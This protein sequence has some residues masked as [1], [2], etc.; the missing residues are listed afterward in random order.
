[1][2]VFPEVLKQILLQFQYYSKPFILDTTGKAYLSF[3]CFK[4]VSCNTFLI[5]EALWG[6]AIMGERALPEKA[7]LSLYYL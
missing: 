2:L 3:G 4:T 5:N 7:L 1:M 6:Q